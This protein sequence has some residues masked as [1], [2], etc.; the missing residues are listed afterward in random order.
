MARE[1]AARLLHELAKGEASAIFGRGR[2]RPGALIYR[3]E[4][5]EDHRPDAGN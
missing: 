2:A 4:D 5:L 3:G 1:V